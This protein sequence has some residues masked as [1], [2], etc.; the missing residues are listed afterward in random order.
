MRERRGWNRLHI[1]Y[2]TKEILRH[3]L[4]SVGIRLATELAWVKVGIINM[5]H[6]DGLFTDNLSNKI[7]KTN[8]TSRPETRGVASRPAAMHER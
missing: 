5:G 7:N 3:K 1:V 6:N 2:Q 4:L 8:T